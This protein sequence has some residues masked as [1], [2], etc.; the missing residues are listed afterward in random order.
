MKTC[1]FC[2]IASRKTASRVIFEDD[3]YLAFEDIH[4]QAPVHFLVV[5]KK[6]IDTHLEADADILGKMMYIAARV[7]EQKGLA[8]DG[9]R[10]I[11]NCKR[12]GG[13]TVYHLHAHVMGGR[14]FTWPPG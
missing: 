9:F 14:W 11:V 1:I 4:P 3:A 6:H 12:H 5:P 13:Q 10:T 2:D 8:A 7:A